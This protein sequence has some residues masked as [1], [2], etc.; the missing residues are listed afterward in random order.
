M[1][2]TDGWTRRMPTAQRNPGGVEGSAAD[3][4]RPGVDG[5]DDVLRAGRP[6]RFCFLCVLSS[7]YHSFPHLHVRVLV[8]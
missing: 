6:H 4:G 8:L 5:A 2:L 7:Y 3:G 1:C